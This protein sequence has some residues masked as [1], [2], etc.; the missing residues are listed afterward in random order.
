M[1]R[2]IFTALAAILGSAILGIDARAANK[3]VPPSLTMEHVE[4]PLHEDVARFRSDFNA[5]FIKVCN[6]WGP[7]FVGRQK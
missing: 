6:W 2:F 7:T 3:C 1:R 4:D 5:G